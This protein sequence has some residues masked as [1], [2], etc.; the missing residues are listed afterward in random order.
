MKLHYG[1]LIGQAYE[2]NSLGQRLARNLGT[3]VAEANAK[4]RSGLRMASEGL[5]TAIDVLRGTHQWTAAAIMINAYGFSETEFT[6][7]EFA[8]DRL[9]S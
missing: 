4:N 9:A 6:E 5:V 3:R 1:R 7:A 8:A 2:L